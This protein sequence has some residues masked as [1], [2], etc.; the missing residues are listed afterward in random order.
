MIKC[1]LCNTIL[2]EEIDGFPLGFLYCPGCHESKD[3][4][5]L[6]DV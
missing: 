6:A 2:V 5:D 4:S 1:S 3:G